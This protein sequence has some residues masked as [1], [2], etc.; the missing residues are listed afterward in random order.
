MKR[1]TYG[2]NY[3]SGCIDNFVL[4]EKFL[5]KRMKSS[6]LIDEIDQN[7]I[8]LAGEMD[9]YKTYDDY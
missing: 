8:V 9:L 1:D 5:K 4:K 6:E 3:R 2:N 7:E